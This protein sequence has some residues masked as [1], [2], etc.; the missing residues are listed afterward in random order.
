MAPERPSGTLTGDDA[1][2]RLRRLFP[3]GETVT[4]PDVI[5]QMG[6]WRRDGASPAG[7]SRLLVN[8]VS[9]VDGRATLGGRSAPLSGTADRALFHGLRSA[10]DA[11][12]V[13]AGTVRM[14]RYGR[15]VKDESIRRLRRERGLREEPL[16]CIVS[17]RLAL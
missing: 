5:E 1:P 8:M 2:V 13:G 17:G 9:T 6:L 15:I 12:L 10:A 16:A 11:V 3:P 4:V 14:E 7:S